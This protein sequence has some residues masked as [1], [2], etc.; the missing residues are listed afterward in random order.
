L[1]RGKEEEAQK[2]VLISET[3]CRERPNLLKTSR[4][5]RAQKEKGATEMSHTVSAGLERGRDK[6]MLTR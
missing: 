4:E 1:K 6:E 2:T 5:R 3:C